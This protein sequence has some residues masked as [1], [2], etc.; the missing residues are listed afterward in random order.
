[1]RLSHKYKLKRILSN[2]MI[3]TL[4]CQLNEALNLYFDKM[5][6]FI[7]NW[8]Q[9]VVTRK[10]LNIKLR[11]AGWSWKLVRKLLQTRVKKLLI[12]YKAH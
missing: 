11:V 8:F 12:K 6:W 7:Y 10:T 5:T 2:E 4:L 9:V 3:V 1:M